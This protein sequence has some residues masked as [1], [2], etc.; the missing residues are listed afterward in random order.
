MVM[1][2]RLED[3]ED[4]PQ[5]DWDR[6]QMFPVEKIIAAAKEQNLL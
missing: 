5:E 3:L 4:K 2:P 6:L 1:N